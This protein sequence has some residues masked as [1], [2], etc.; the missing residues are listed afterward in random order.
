M[1]DRPRVLLATDG[2]GRPADR[3]AR[4]L[5]AVLAD[6]FACFV[7]PHFDVR[8]RDYAAAVAFAWGAAG[9]LAANA[10][11][12]RLVLAVRDAASWN[13]A[14]PAAPGTCRVCGPATPGGRFRAAAN[15]GAA[16]AVA[17]AR[18]A[19]DLPAVGLPV[20]VAE[21]GVDLDAFAF[22]PPA[23]N[24]VVGW[25]GAPADAVVIRA[26]CGT[27]GVTD[28]APIGLPDTAWHGGVA[29]YVDATATDATSAGLLEAMACGRPVVATDAG[30]ARELVVPGVNGV[31]VARD[32]AAIA[33]AVT[34][35][36][37][38]DLAAMGRAARATAERHGWASKAVAW[39]AAL[40]GDAM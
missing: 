11:P 2:S 3:A 18:L 6:E 5:A 33:A 25:S 37:G 22:C 34:A 20:Y 9:S 23:A 39:G 1:P 14:V 38:S 8:H 16:L 19:A 27:A 30:L 7:E 35:L 24:M 21:G 13:D 10:R 32:P 36:H 12:R 4:A 17:T 28:V 40:R 15:H 29:I 31:L 26:A